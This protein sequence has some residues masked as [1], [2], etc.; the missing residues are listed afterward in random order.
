MK[1]LNASIVCTTALKKMTGVSSGRVIFQNCRHFEAPSRLA[2][3][4]MSVG[5]WRRPAR[6]MIIGEPNCQIDRMIS[7]QSE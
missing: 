3:S 5:I 2:A 6:K 4:Y 7:V 1:A